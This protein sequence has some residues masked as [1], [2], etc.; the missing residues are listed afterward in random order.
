[1]YDNLSVLTLPACGLALFV[2]GWIIAAVALALAV[3]SLAHDPEKR[4]A[5]FGQDHAQT[6]S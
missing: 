1:M 4:E 3:R 5:V 6:K 2:L